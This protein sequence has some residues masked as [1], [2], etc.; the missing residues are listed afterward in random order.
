VNPTAD[1]AAALYDNAYALLKNKNYDRAQEEFDKFMA[2]YPTHGLAG[3]AK[4]WLGETY[5]VRGKYD[6]AARLF[7]EG[8]QQ[9]PDG[10]K[11]ADNLLKLGMALGAL[12]KKEDACIALAQ[13]DKETGANLASV[14]RRAE[15]EKTRLGC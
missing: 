4:Y 3:N 7:A 5:Y 8:Y 9:Y 15:Q 1:S 12:G 2:E 14:Q 13:L 10:S 11:T 6:V